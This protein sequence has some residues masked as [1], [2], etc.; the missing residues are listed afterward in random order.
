ML[1]GQ[2]FGDR[3]NK[4]ISSES[5]LLI[6][7]SDSKSYVITS[8]RLSYS[9]PKKQTLKLLLLLELYY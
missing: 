3:S 8:I 4:L 1:S 2:I 9:V 7:V 5:I 6:S